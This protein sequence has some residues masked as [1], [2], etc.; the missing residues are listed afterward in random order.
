MAIG[1]LHVGIVQR[2]AGASSV[3]AAAYASRSR[4]ID[5]RTGQIYDYSQQQGDVVAS[6]IALPKN[7]PA[8]FRDRATLWNAMETADKRKNSQTGRK[9]ILALPHELTAQQQQWLLKDYEKQFTRKGLAVDVSIHRPH[10]HGDD[11]ND[12]AH[13]NIPTRFID[14]SGVGKKDRDSNEREALQRWRDEWEKQV[15]RHLERHGH[16]ASISMATL[17]A[18]GIDREPQIHIGQ[19][20]SALERK[21]VQTERGDLHRGIANDNRERA[22]D[23]QPALQTYIA[24]R[25]R[26]FRQQ[27]QVAWQAMEQQG[28]DM[29]GRHSQTRTGLQQLHDEINVPQAA[30]AGFFSF[31]SRVGGFFGLQPKTPIKRISRGELQRREKQRDERELLKETQAQELR[32]WEKKRASLLEQQ[33]YGRDLFERQLLETSSLQR[34]FERSKDNAVQAMETKTQPDRATDQLAERGRDRDGPELEL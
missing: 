20:A 28:R 24:E 18:Q 15:N 27:Q 34:A 6:W 19:A 25:R 32:Q 2:S 22:N 11:R 21:G 9:M 4:L 14:A 26:Q 31:L 3:D 33:A 7:A 30:Q 17:E 13:L 12:H 1:H 23:N 29:L 16:E 5:E 8:R 10:A